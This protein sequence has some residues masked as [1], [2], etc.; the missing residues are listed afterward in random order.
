M[1]FH[2]VT[3]IAA[4]GMFSNNRPSRDKSLTYL[5]VFSNAAVTFALR[6]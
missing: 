5:Q 3:P 6:E 4:E 1:V 2:H